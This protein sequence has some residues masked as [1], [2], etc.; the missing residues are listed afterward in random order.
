MGEKEIGR[1]NMRR[2]E[3]EGDKDR[4]K[5]IEEEMEESK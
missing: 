3:R 5:R 4:V 2:R 1:Q